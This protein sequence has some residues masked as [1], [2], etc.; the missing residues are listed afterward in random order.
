MT[1]LRSLS[2]LACLYY[3]FLVYG[4]LRWGFHNEDSHVGRPR[5]GGGVGTTVIHLR[6]SVSLWR[7]LER[8]VG[9]SRPPPQPVHRFVRRDTLTWS[10]LGKFQVCVQMGVWP[11]VLSRSPGDTLPDKCRSL[12]SFVLKTTHTHK[13]IL[14]VTE[15]PVFFSPS[16]S[17]FYNDRNLMSFPEIPF[18]VSVQVFKTSEHLRFL[19]SVLHFVFILIFKPF[20]SLSCVSWN[21]FSF[22]LIFLVNLGV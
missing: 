1:P 6:P 15:V 9:R 22:L 5:Y 7:V 3:S 16:P 8:T 21:C 4:I 10:E 2:W 20:G 17:F 14:V 13:K 11:S 18:T 12:S 19:T